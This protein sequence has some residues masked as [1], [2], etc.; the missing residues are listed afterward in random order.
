MIAIML[1]GCW[2]DVGGCWGDV[3]GCGGH[4]GDV[5]AEYICSELDHSSLL[6]ELEVTTDDHSTGCVY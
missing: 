6:T 2:G 3:G 1:G 4:V 5:G